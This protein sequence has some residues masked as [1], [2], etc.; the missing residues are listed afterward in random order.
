MLVLV[1][2][3]MLY[4]EL[5]KSVL[6][7]LYVFGSNVG[8]KTQTIKRHGLEPMKWN[9]CCCC[10]W[11]VAFTSHYGTGSVDELENNDD[12]GKL[13]F[14][15]DDVTCTW[16]FHAT[17]VSQKAI[18]NTSK[19][20]VSAS[21]PRL[22]FIPTQRMKHRNLQKHRDL[23]AGLAYCQSSGWCARTPTE[24]LSGQSQLRHTCVRVLLWLCE[25][26]TLTLEEGKQQQQQ[27]QPPPPCAHLVERVT[28]TFLPS[29]MYDQ[30]SH[31]DERG[32]I[33]NGN[34]SELLDQT[35]G[36]KSGAFRLC[37]LIG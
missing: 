19:F 4:F 32:F 8:T 7:K 24:T 36:Q 16:L 33:P 12:T 28:G 34:D 10:C 27:Q 17:Q 3:R 13:R 20:R 6:L 35:G 18:Y 25:E 9:C 26:R 1:E 37:V 14:L 21:R 29:L 23:N 11:H 15:R 22:A 31:F 5:I 2:I 30:P